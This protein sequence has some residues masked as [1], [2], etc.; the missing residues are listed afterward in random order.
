MLKN[1]GLTQDQW[2]AVTAAA[3]ATAYLIYSLAEFGSDFQT[4][5]Q[6]RQAEQVS[7]RH[8]AICTHLGK[9]PASADHDSCM[10][11]LFD[12]KNWHQKL[13]QEENESLL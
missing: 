4:A 11:T 13:F 10:A 8:S 7:M 1:F 5:R 9:L 2:A 12:L 3:L 6:S